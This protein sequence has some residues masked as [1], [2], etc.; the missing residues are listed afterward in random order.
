MDPLSS[1]ANDRAAQ[2]PVILLTG[3]LGAGKTTLLNALLRDPAFADTAV[4]INEF[5][6][7]E[8]DHD[9]I[10]DFSDELITTTTGCLCCTAS[11]DVK[12]ALFDLW[13]RRKD[14]EIGPFRR[15]LVETTGLLDPAPVLNALLTPHAPGLVDN[16]VKQQFAL[17]RVIAVFDAVAGPDS[18]KRRWEAVRQLAF[19]DMAVLTK[20]DLPEAREVDRA[21]LAAIN[22]GLRILD[23]SRDGP[24]VRA[25]LREPQHYD[26]RGKSD[27][28]LDWLESERRHAQHHH[29]HDHAHDHHAHDHHN[30]DHH[31]HDHHNHDHGCGAGAVGEHGVVSQTF[32]GAAPLS[33][34]QLKTLLATLREMAGQDLL[35]LKGLLALGEDPER[36]LVLH[37]VQH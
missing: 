1:P 30:H 29:E 36:P 2:I 19:A 5:G 16:I 15:V 37:G 31:N 4:L 22:P 3:F 12:Q 26:L 8:V 11:S 7:V 27:D 9:L 25:L 28:A 32:F 21:A 10:A 6:D 17:A 18:L 13:R 20:T 33:A 14:R 34:E 35:R 24:K 23:G